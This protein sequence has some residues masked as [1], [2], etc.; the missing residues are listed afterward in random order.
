MYFT[1]ILRS[2][3]DGSC[4][5]GITDNLKRRIAEHNSG[6]VTYTSSKSP[7]RLVWFCGFPTKKKA[8]EFELYLKSHS[9]IAFRNKRLI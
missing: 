3:K 7:F 6:N 8:L 5:T 1:Y 2:D 4:Y 9:G